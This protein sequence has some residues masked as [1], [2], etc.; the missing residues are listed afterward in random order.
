MRYYKYHNTDKTAAEVRKAQYRS[1]CE[2]DKRTVRRARRW[3][4]AA[5]AVLFTLYALLFAGGL[6][7]INRI[8][9]AQPWPLK[10]L[11]G[12][13]R[14]L[15]IVVLFILCA[16]PAVGISMPLWQKAESFSLPAMKR[17]FLAEGCAHLRRHYK[18][19]EPY[20][21]TKCF[22]AADKR[23]TN[24]DVCLFSANGE[25]RITTD[26]LHGFLHGE[27]DLGCYC[28]RAEEVTLTRQTHAGRIALRLQAG[29]ADF[30]LG[31]RAK[32]FVSQWLASA[33]E[34]PQ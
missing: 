17:R 28:L 18:F 14:A 11:L 1:L 33:D 4:R 25:L 9:T 15:L 13:G 31:W 6:F 22:A 12:A 7:L 29:S 24:H 8:P 3:R 32:Q 5:F 16:V 34:A 26:I 27:R 23:F 19:S 30:L 21:I 10:I 2:D 20:L